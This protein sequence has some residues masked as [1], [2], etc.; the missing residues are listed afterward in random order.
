MTHGQLKRRVFDWLYEQGCFVWNN[1]TGSWKPEGQ[2]RIY[3]GKKGSADVLGLTRHGRHIEV[4]VK[5]KPDKQNEDQV[6]HQQEVESRNGIY[7]LVYSLDD[8]EARKGEIA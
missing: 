8:L 2:P 7:V 3:Y 4:E 5:V 6:K 1:N